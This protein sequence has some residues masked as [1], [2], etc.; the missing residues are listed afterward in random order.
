MNRA[1]V[2]A[3]GLPVVGC[4]DGGPAVAELLAETGAD[5]LMIAAMVHDQA[6]RLRPRARR[7]PWPRAAR[8]TTTC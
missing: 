8:T 4:P 1:F 2:E 3:A 5:E 6:D 7:R